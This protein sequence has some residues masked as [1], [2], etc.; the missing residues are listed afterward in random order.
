MSLHDRGASQVEEIIS[1]LQTAL[2]DLSTVLGLLCGPLEC[3]GLL[4]PQFRRYNA[5]PL[6]PGA[7][8]ISRHIPAFQREILQHIG[9]TWESTLAEKEAAALLEQYFCPD[10]FSFAS[11]V[12]GDVTLLAYSTL[13]SLPLTEYSIRLLVR[14]SERYPIDR[15]HSAVFSR[16]NNAKQTLGWEDCVRNI[17]AV[18]ARVANSLRGD[19]VPLQLEHGFYFGAVCKR[20]ECAI[21]SLSPSPRGVQCSVASM[22]YLLTK[23]VNVGTFPPTQP[24]SRSQPSFFQATIP[25][26]RVRLI[27]ENSASYSAAWARILRG[28]TSSFTLQS[29][30]TSLFGSLDAKSGT[31]SSS[32]QRAMV[33]R[34]S[35]LVLGLLGPV[36]SDDT[37]LWESVSAVILSREWSEAHARIFVCWVAGPQIDLTALE[38]LLNCVVDMWSSP[39]HVKHSLLNHHRY[40]TTLLLVTLSYFPPS[41]PELLSLA[42]SPAFISGVG[43]YIGHL[44][45]AV[46]RCGMLAA[47]VVASLSGK[48]LDFG[49]WEGDEGE[50]VWAKRVRG[51]LKARDVDANLGDLEEVPPSAEDIDIQ[52]ISTPGIQSARTSQATADVEA[53]YDSDDSLSGY[54][55]QSSSRSVSP[56]PSEL[57]EIEK[58]PTL[59]V[60]LKKVPPPVY[61]A[62]LGALIRPAGSLKV[63]ENQQADEVEMGLNCAEELIRKKKGYGTELEENAVNLVHGLVGLQNNYELEGFS[64]KRQGA[65]NALVSCSPRTAAPCIIEE[66]FKNQYSTDQRYAMLNALALGARE[67]ASLSVP[68]S[69]VPQSRIAF[70]S[71]TLHTHLHRMYLEDNIQEGVLPQILDDISREALNRDAET[72][73][74][75]VPELVRER[76]LRVQKPPGVTEV[77]RHRTF[78]VPL[79]QNM[80]FNE[81]AAQYF[82]APLINRFWLFFRDEQT[83]E[84]RTAHQDG[85]QRYQG[86]GTGLILNPI[87]L[88]H[89]LATLAILVHASKNAPEWLAVIGP[90]ALELAI[91]VGTKPVSTMEADD[92]EILGSKS[93]E[94]SVLSTALELALVVLDGCLELDGGR[95]LG[96]DHTALLLGV[97]EWA[98][99]VFSRLEKGA[100]MEGGGGVQEV[101]LKRAA[102]GVLLKVDSLTSRWRRS[103]I[104]T[105]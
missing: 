44:D 50:K 6:P 63:D 92:E 99:A 75:K 3:I 69:S 37:E 91:T 8:N 94:A 56:T 70:P 60:G 103:M 89:F 32:R 26:I 98:T 97:G 62:Q 7:V 79:K 68:P 72:N 28:F 45:S 17:A 33:K 40:V 48:K 14:L 83:R 64:A 77:E 96:L 57:A 46:R 22:T 47:E 82:T 84:E 76:R 52:E 66:F 54:V 49:D 87:V 24:S 21:A 39:D 73:V 18:P 102:A 80:T 42:L 41:Y 65:L 5:E 36:V 78:H 85:R 9:P 86:A 95:A 2:S 104:D 23:L 93:K 74:D 1:R 58:D 105:A 15:L 55:S 61:L 100:K 27:Q 13:L 12:A 10:A 31:D 29:I 101:K 67:L 90:D 81:V 43:R 59:S 38:I 53:G 35:R 20:C 19:K 25:Q 30:V 4:P 34:E 16:E 51:L 88:S 11:P 71:K